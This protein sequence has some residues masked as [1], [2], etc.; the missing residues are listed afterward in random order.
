MKSITPYSHA[1]ITLAATLAT[2]PLGL[3][4]HAALAMAAL[5]WLVSSLARDLDGY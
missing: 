5:W 1:A 3:H 2:A 4:I